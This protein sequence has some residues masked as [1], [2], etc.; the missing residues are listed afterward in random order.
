V[1]RR[2]SPSNR[3][4]PAAIKRHAKEF[5]M[6]QPLFTKSALAA[7]LVSLGLAVGVSAQTPSQQP[8]GGTAATPAP[9]AAGSTG[10]DKGAGSTAT[11]G[12]TAPA[13][14]PAATTA[15]ATSS[16]TS[17]E[18][19]FLEKAA[20]G[21]MAEI[22][23]GKLAMEKASAPQVKD[24][25]KRIVDDHTKALDE[26][27]KLAGA[28]GVTLPAE[29]DAKHRRLH[30]K[31]AKKSG[32]DFDREYTDEMEDEHSK[33]VREFKSMAKSA[34]DADV[35][36][37]AS[38]TLPTLE[39]HLQMAKSAEDAAKHA[40]R[41]PSAAQTSTAR[42]GTG[43]ASSAKSGSNSGSTTASGMAAG[44]PSAAGAPGSSGR[45]ASA[46]SPDRSGAGTAAPSGSQGAGG[47]TTGSPPK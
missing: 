23:L 29:V 21:S 6:S 32:N 37:F 20:Q 13:T 44:T 24:L 27:K 36:S 15:K 9:P 12:T 45:A 3:S 14:K 4:A 40:K 38:A 43:S 19:K 35:K 2:G 11:K 39:Q 26:V 8:S 34:K 42:T 41:D 30:D 7:A 17:S 16:L 47:A 5:D 18:R 46:T 31:L 10:M 28:K 1:A 22:E 25:A 33:D